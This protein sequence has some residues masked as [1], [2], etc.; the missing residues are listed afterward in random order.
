[1]VPTPAT[2]ATPATPLPT[3]D[4]RY[5]FDLQGYVLLKGVLSDDEVSTLNARI[6]DAGIAATSTGTDDDDFDTSLL[7]LGQPFLDLID[8]PGVLP[9]LEEW[10]DPAVR[11][12]HVY[13]IFS[14]RGAPTLDLHGSA[15]PYIRLN[16]YH[17]VNGRIYSG[18]TVVQYALTPVPAG[19]GGFACIPG[20]HKSAFPLPG[21]IRSLKGDVDPAVVHVPMDPGDVLIF[22]EALTHG[23][24]PW[25]ADHQRRSLLYKYS[26]GSMAWS[27]Q[28]WPADVLDAMSPRQRLL[29]EPPYMVHPETGLRRLPADPERSWVAEY[30]G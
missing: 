21:H 20:S 16:H 8:H 10:V 18:L 13:P 3:D 6:D 14:E 4:D 11:L 22:T 30:G 19:K 27:H 15:T 1:M 12:D 24:F 29:A 7:R 26:P 9:Y 17:C 5:R 23:T 2:P 28:V 25:T